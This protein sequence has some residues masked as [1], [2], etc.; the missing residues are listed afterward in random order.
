MTSACRNVCPTG[1]PC[2]GGKCQC[3][4]GATDV[5]SDPNNCGQCGNV[6]GGKGSYL[7]CNGQCKSVFD[8]DNCGGCGVTC[9]PPA[10]VR[11]CNCCGKS[12]HQIDCTCWSLILQRDTVLSITVKTSVPNTLGTAF[13]AP[14]RVYRVDFSLEFGSK[15]LYAGGA[16]SCRFECMGSSSYMNRLFDKR[17]SILLCL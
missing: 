5:M 12:N 11:V 14:N 16:V 1:V 15:Y 7:C 4:N 9:R 13:N 10:G 8:N 17:L 3:P 2:T 6:C